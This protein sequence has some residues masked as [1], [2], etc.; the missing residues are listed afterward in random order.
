MQQGLRLRQ[1][2]GQKHSMHAFVLTRG[3][4]ERHEVNGVN[5][6]S[7][8]EQLEER[9]LAVCARFS[10]HHRTCVPRHGLPVSPHEFAIALHVGLLQIGRQPT[11]VFGVGQHGVGAESEGIL[12]P[13]SEK[14]EKHGHILFKGS[15]SHVLVDRAGTRQECLEVFRPNG[16]GNAHADRSPHGVAPA[17]PIFK[18]KGLVL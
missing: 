10:P 17:D 15:V 3:R 7:L 6:C 12:I 1:R 5:L 13:V 8:V 9:V 16:Q 18:P 14:G 4:L 2:I 11:K